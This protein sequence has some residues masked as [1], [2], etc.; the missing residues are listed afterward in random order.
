MSG[1][2]LQSSGTL[3]GPVGARY[4]KLRSYSS[5]P[6]CSTLPTYKVPRPNGVLWGPSLGQT[7][8]QDL[9]DERELEAN[10]VMYKVCR[11]LIY[12]HCLSEGSL[13]SNYSLLFQ[14]T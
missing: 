1:V 4:H 7:T 3:L 5:I 10:P 9:R 11:L 13:P 12:S 8:A 2:D 14:E 6:Q